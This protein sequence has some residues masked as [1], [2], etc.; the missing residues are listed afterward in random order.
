MGIEDSCLEQAKAISRVNGRHVFN[1]PPKRIKE[2]Q[3]IVPKT[4]GL[5]AKSVVNYCIAVRSEFEN[6]SFAWIAVGLWKIING[7]KVFGTFLFSNP[8]QWQNIIV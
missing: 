7:A 1:I 2:N 6:P 4:K 5:G 3:V 8:I